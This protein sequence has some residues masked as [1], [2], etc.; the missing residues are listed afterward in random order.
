MVRARA[1]GLH[2]VFVTNGYET[3]E[4]IELVAPYL[5]AANVDLKAASDAFYRRVCGAAG[6]RSATPSW[7]CAGAA[8]GSS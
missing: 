3:P 5:D 2:N 8:S 1:A 4:A 6:S 7:R